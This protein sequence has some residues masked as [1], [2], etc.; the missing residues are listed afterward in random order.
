[1]HKLHWKMEKQSPFDAPAS[2]KPVRS[3][4]KEKKLGGRDREKEG[5]KKRT[6]RKINLLPR[7]CKLPN[8]RLDKEDTNLEDGRAFKGE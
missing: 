6:V 4:S 8:I 1:V 2:R 5:V 7:L 3:K